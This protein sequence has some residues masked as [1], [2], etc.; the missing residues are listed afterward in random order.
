M[1]YVAMVMG[2]YKLCTNKED[3]PSTKDK[4]L[5]HKACPH[6]EVP[7]YYGSKTDSKSVGH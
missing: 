2:G 5:G 3:N 4:M 6:S 1:Y 7:L